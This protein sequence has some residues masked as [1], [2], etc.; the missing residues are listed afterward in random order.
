MPS[1]LVRIVLDIASN[2][3]IVEYGE[4]RVAGLTQSQQNE[5]KQLNEDL[6]LPG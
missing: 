3:F 1:Q 2:N 6:F 5:M 4:R